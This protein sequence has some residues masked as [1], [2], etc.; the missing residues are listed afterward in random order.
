MLIDLRKMQ[1]LT[2]VSNVAPENVIFAAKTLVLCLCEY[3]DCDV[4]NGIERGVR[5]CRHDHRRRDASVA[6]RENRNGIGSSVR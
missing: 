3:V 6:T 2:K 1:N 4:W 5:L